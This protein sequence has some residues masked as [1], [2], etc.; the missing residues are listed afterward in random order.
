[1]KRLI[2]VICLLYST[3]FWAQFGKDPLINLENFDKYR[4]HWGYY[5]GFNSY[6]FKFNYN[7]AGQDVL[8]KSTNGFNVGLI[9]DLKII[10][11][12]NLRFEPGLAFGNRLLTFSNFSTKSQRERAVTSTYIHLPLLL[13]FSAER[14]GNIRPFVVGGFS[15][16]LN[17]SSNF[18]SKDDNSTGVFRMQ[19][20]TTNY[21]V[22]FGIELYLEYFK[23]VPSIRGVFGIND[24]LIRDNDPNS[25]YTGNVANMKSRG[26]FI[27]FAFH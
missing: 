13:K 4:I 24:E 26:V 9:G 22:G 2:G 21:E 6:D 5:L 17:L 10:D 7:I 18:K 3:C 11:H 15:K 25:G 19:K 16:S 23:F 12:I 27:N 1:M 20:W 14:A 8:V